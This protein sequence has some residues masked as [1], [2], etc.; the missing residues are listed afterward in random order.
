MSLTNCSARRK[1][2]L[3]YLFGMSDLWTTLSLRA[4]F[5]RLWLNNTFS[6]KQGM[7]LGSVSDNFD[8]FIEQKIFH[9]DIVVDNA[10]VAAETKAYKPILIIT[11]FTDKDDND[12]SKEK[13]L[14]NYNHIKD[15]VNQIV[16][17]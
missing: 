12:R 6:L 16:R 2:S 3:T 5:F 14:E 15:E 13:V 8:E 9:T 7:F 17:N 1:R 10:R 4:R 11:D